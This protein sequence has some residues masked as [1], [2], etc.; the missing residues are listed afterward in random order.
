M[1]VQVKICGIST[2]ETLDAAIAGGAS[3]IGLVFVPNSPRRID[4]A[5][6]ASLAARAAGKARIVGLFVNPEAGLIAQ[7]RQQVKLDIAQLHG[8]ESPG[9]VADT[10]AT[11]IE[12]WK[13][14]PVRTSAD[15][16]AGQ[17]YQGAA[18]FLLYDAKPPKGADRPGGNGMRFDWRLLE[19]F[20]HPL[21]WIL[22]GGLDPDNISEA[23]AV[24]NATVL[25]VSSGVESAPGI[26][27]MD[28]I[29]AFLKAAHHL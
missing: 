24:T 26:K 22:S 6:A 27:D 16:Q 1:A 7:A 13:A 17:T 19:G 11:G 9:F 3:H 15:L 25:D 18:D 10:R 20:R 28:K 12:V 21:P 8:D 4:F 23:V 14:L 2:P 5:Q 29:A